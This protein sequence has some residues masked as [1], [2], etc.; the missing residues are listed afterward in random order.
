V[1]L[2]ISLL[3][4]LAAVTTAPVAATHNS[5]PNNCDLST[6]FEK[7]IGNSSNPSGIAR[8][9]M[10]TI[11]T[12]GDTFAP[13][14]HGINSQAGGTHDEVDAYV[15]L[16]D[17]T[18]S[19][20]FARVGIIRCNYTLD[21]VT[22]CDDNGDQAHFIFERD[23]CGQTAQIED[24]GLADHTAHEYQ[25]YVYNGTLFVKV[26]G[27]VE[28]STD[29]SNSERLSC[30][31]D[32][33]NDVRVTARGMFLDGGDL[34]AYSSDKLNFDN[35]AY[36]NFNGTTWLNPNFTSPCDSTDSS[37]E[38]IAGCTINNGQDFD[39]WQTPN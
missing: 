8:G 33:S 39:I 19:G 34:L 3:L 31:L 15:G 14:S 26:D 32:E 38:L 7:E 16:E 27:V 17:T 5:P 18:T 10:G 12:Y 28:Y 9:V 35:V 25:V 30:W 22:Y 21:T 24:L 13:C 2:C 1:G 29:V 37:S 36:V 6:S 11:D 4:T 23:G 20:N